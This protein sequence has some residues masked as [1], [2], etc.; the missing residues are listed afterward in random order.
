[1]EVVQNVPIVCRN[2]FIYR[3]HHFPGH[4]GPL[5]TKYYILV[6]FGPFCGSKSGFLGPKVIVFWHSC[7]EVVPKCPN[8]VQKCTYISFISLSGTFWAVIDE[9]SHFGPF[10]SILRV[11]KRVLG[12][13]VIVCWYCYIEVVP[14]CHNIVQKCIYIWFISLWGTFWSVIDEILLF[15]PFSSILR[16]KKRV[17]GP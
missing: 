17:F 4:S 3:L 9:K 2:A 15:S 8:S 7:I 5:L 10:S 12:P 6:H 14:K 13:N 1:M 16:V 11:K